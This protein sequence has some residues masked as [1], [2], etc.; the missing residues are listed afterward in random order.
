MRKGVVL[1]LVAVPVVVLAGAGCAGCYTEPRLS[2][3]HPASTAGAAAPERERV[4]R[5]DA[6]AA[7]PVGETRAAAGDTPA[8]GH[9]H[10]GHDHAGH[11]QAGH[12]APAAAV[13]VYTCPMHPEVVSAEPGRC[14]KCGM[15]LVKRGGEE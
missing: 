5:L 1:G 3:D 7:E 4:G 8:A 10:A 2:D 14:P 11:E 9:D 12:D 13:A 6:S 15:A